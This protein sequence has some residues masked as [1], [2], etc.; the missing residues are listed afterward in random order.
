[1]Q[2]RGFFAEQ[3]LKVKLVRFDTAQPLM[4]S[5]VAGNLQAGGYTALPITFTAMLRGKTE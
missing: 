1:V 3:G 2:S 5:L 4:Q